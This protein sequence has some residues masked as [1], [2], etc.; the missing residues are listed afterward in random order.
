MPLPLDPETYGFYSCCSKTI[1]N[2]CYYANQFR[3]VEGILQA[4]CPFCRNV[5]PTT[6]GGMNELLTKRIAVNDP[7]AICEMGAER[8]KEG[9]FRAA[10]EYYRK[11][12]ALG[13][14]HSHYQ[15][16]VMYHYGN[17][18]DKD[19]EKELYHLKEAAIAGHPHARYNLACFEGRNGQHN[20]AAKHFIIAAKLGDDDSLKYAKEMYKAGHVSKED[21]A[22]ALRGHHAAIKAM[23]SPQ[24]EQAAGFLAELERRGMSHFR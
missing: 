16:S 7:V 10:I 15:L 11:A 22:A 5:M 6:K 2:G 23:K 12:A 24:R 19:E 4:T 13:D 1:C 20:R 3:G 8:C 21:F 9:D 17:G 14:V 18:V